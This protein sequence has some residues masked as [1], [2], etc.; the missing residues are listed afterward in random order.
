[1]PAPDVLEQAVAV[2]RLIVVADAH[3]NGHCHDTSKCPICQAEKIG[4]GFGYK[5]GYNTAIRD[6][7]EQ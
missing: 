5:A 1:M 7:A 4:Y 2:H 6:V 3:L